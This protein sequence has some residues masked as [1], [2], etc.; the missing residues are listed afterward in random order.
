MNIYFRGLSCTNIN[1]AV[2]I[3]VILSGV[4][5]GDYNL[6]LNVFDVRFCEDDILLGVRI[7]KAI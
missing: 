7:S 5:S 2:I 1:S 3:I 6:S 4:S